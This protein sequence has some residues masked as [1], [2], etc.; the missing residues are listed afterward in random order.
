MAVITLRPKNITA[1]MPIITFKGVKNDKHK[2]GQIEPVHDA[3]QAG[4]DRE[5]ETLVRKARVHSK[6]GGQ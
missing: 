1:E 3:G 2:K 6:D 5:I 4:L